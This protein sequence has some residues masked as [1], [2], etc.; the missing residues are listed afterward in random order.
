MEVCF[1]I[2]IFQSGWL[3]A[4]L[5]SMK[6]ASTPWCLIFN[7]RL[8]FSM[9]GNRERSTRDAVKMPQIAP[10]NWALPVAPYII[11]TVSYRLIQPS[12]LCINIETMYMY[13]NWKMKLFIL[14]SLVKYQVQ[15]FTII[16]YIY[17]WSYVLEMHEK[18]NYEARWINF[19]LNFNHRKHKWN[20]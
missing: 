12:T 18:Q 7:L 13:Y 1:A 3:F 2:R 14:V 15:L 19:L 6:R 17:I 8:S 10:L 4:L 20:D 5:T 9:L 16:S 11:G